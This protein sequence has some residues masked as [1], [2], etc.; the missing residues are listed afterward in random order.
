MHSRRAVTLCNTSSCSLAASVLECLKL[1]RKAISLP[2]MNNWDFSR[3]NK[4]WNLRRRPFNS[5]IL[6]SA[7]RAYVDAN[8]LS[9]Y[10]PN[11]SVATGHTSFFGKT[12]QRKSCVKKGHLIYKWVSGW[13]MRS[14]GLWSQDSLSCLFISVDQNPITW[15]MMHDQQWSKTFDVASMCIPTD[16]ASTNGLSRFCCTRQHLVFSCDWRKEKI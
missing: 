9:F 8:L 7:S 5:T 11:I 6:M 3:G 14:T 10:W 4:R 13:A 16:I 12:I 2:E 15:M 1:S